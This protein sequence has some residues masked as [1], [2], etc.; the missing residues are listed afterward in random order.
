MLTHTPLDLEIRIFY[1]CVH[2]WWIE[3]YLFGPK[4]RC[5]TRSLLSSTNLITGFWRLSLEGQIE[6]VC[7]QRI[8]YSCLL[9]WCF[10]IFAQN[11]MYNLEE[12]LLA[13]LDKVALHMALLHNIL[14]ASLDHMKFSFI[15]IWLWNL[16]WLVFANITL[17]SGGFSI[18]MHLHTL[19]IIWI[20]LVD[21]YLAGKN[22][23]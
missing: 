9:L 20:S 17:E 18:F 21:G 14:F 10:Q 15:H 12:V 6:L 23:V 16:F 4:F 7:K 1:A 2:S 8:V 13:H 11:F 5:V 22:G 19:L 3:Y